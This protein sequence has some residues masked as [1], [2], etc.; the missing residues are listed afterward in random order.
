MWQYF[1]E[2]LGYYPEADNM[3]LYQ[4][5]AIAWDETQAIYHAL[6]Q[7]KQEG[8]VLCRPASRCVCLG[9]HD[10]ADQE[11]NRAYCQAANI[12]LIRRDIGGG[13]V[14]LEPNQI[15]FQLVLRTDN[16]LL[17]GRREDFFAKFLEPVVRTLHNFNIQASLKRPADIVVNGKKISGNGAG[18]INGLA[19]YT[20]N[21][22][23][24]FDRRTM[25]NVLNVPSTRFRELTRLSMERYLTTMAEEVGYFPNFNSIEER[26]IANFSD[27]IPNLRPTIYSETLKI[28]VKTTAR[29]LTSQEFL[30][31]PGKHTTVRQV[32]INEGTYIRLHVFPGCGSLQAACRENCGC[33]VACEG[34]GLAIILLQDGK[35]RE[36]EMQGVR[37]L[38][39]NSRLVTPFLLDI[40]WAEADIKA[41]LV[42]WRQSNLPDSIPMSNKT[43][44]DWLLYGR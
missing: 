3:N 25:A 21:I 16:S 33:Q 35:I 20:G 18:D 42:K 17:T 34:G 19:V 32:K 14:L 24:A 13:V 6:A 10:D 2:I 27:W 1:R 5:G 31:L 11:V 37:C 23:I 8:L 36:F 41:A 28:A 38:E 29:Q 4:L 22:L 15:F 7:I 44:L 9:L 40:A 12:P 26:L 43:L 30:E 39:Q